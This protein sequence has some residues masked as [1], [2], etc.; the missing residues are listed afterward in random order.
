MFN[1]LTLGIVHQGVAFPVLWWMLDKK[2]NSNTSEGLDLFEGFI[3]LFAEHEIAY[4]TAYREFLGQDWLSYL[5]SQ[6]MIPFP[7]PIRE[8]DCLGDGRH[9]LATRVVFSHLKIGHFK[10]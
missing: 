3:E 10:S 4:V 2:G 9:I 6:P 8:S 5:F 1:I 7:I